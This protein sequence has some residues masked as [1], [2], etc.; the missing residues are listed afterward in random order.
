MRSRP[1][2][3]INLTAFNLSSQPFLNLVE[4][5]RAL[6]RFVLWK[7][8]D[9]KSRFYDLFKEVYRDKDEVEVV[10]V[11]HELRKSSSMLKSLP[12]FLFAFEEL[13]Q[14]EISFSFLLF[15]LRH[16]K[17]TLI[18]DIAV[19]PN[20]G[21]LLSVEVKAVSWKYLNKI[22]VVLPSEQLC[23]QL[24]RCFYNPL[25]ASRIYHRFFNLKHSSGSSTQDWK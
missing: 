14:K 20:N 6:E 7:V 24:S 25:V 11:E 4:S 13:L 18:N 22:L 8:F 19:E 15:S 1:H 12:F 17:K 16:Q 23:Q 2:G 10:K 21:R 3:T 9:H 5:N